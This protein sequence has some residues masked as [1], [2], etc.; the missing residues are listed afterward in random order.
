METIF[1]LDMLTS[2]SVSVLT[3]TFND[4]GVQVG[5][6]VRKAYMNTSE[7]REELKGIL[8]DEQFGVLIEAWGE[9][10]TVSVIELPVLELSID[11]L[12]IS[13][14]SQMNDVC[15]KTIIEGFDL[16][17]DNGE[18]H[19]FSLKIEDQLKIQALALKAQSGETVL[20]YHAD[21]QSCR[22]F[23]VNEIMN[24][25]KNMED[26]IEYQTTY[27]NSLRNYIN[28]VETK[29]ELLDIAY[30]MT[31]PIEYQSEVFKTLI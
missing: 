27:F 8:P 5:N 13:I 25:N 4:E 6:N 14:I 26:I 28:S 1:T 18:T 17:L 15:N 29:D 19:H 9:T 24:L 30:G 11:K 7:Q 16:E 10:P 31:I 22:F 2:E 20:P 12:K 3:Q 23:S 21:N